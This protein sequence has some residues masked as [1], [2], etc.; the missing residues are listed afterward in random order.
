MISFTCVTNHTAVA[1]ALRHTQCYH[2]CHY[3]YFYYSC[4]YNYYQDYHL[5]NIG[6]LI[7]RLIRRYGIQSSLVSWSTSSNNCTHKGVFLKCVLSPKPPFPPP[8]A[9]PL[10]PH[11]VNPL[12]NWTRISHATTKT[13]KTWLASCHPIKHMH[14]SS[15]PNVARLFIKKKKK[16]RQ[17][18]KK[19][20][21]NSC[22]GT[23]LFWL[24]LLNV[25]HD[26][27]QNSVIMVYIESLVN[28]SKNVLLGEV[29]CN[30]S[31]FT[32]THFGLKWCSQGRLRRE[33]VTQKDVCW[34]HWKS[35]LG[36]ELAIW[37][38]KCAFLCVH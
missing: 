27:K 12:A 14:T 37:W 16:K 18:K 20:K 24:L 21:M 10:L 30:W 8:T 23:D 6:K 32:R 25:S 22:R 19:I 35:A 36:P 38:C 26:Y 31:V 3:Y 28:G 4:S 34:S 1:S 15:L 33:R 2:D 9:R 29:S 17:K 5:W 13:Y 7:W 11:L